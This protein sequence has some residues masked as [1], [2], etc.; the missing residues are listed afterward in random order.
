[1]IYIAYPSKTSEE[2]KQVFNELSETFKV[3]T[4]EDRHQF[5][6][7]EF[8]KKSEELLKDSIVFMAEFSEPSSGVEIETNW[9][10]ENKIPIIFFLREGSDYPDSL[11]DVYL[12]VIRYADAEEL[13]RKVNELLNE[14]YLEESKQEFFEYSDKKQY[15]AYKKGWKRKY[16]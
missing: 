6:R 7:Y 5:S 2:I 14:E 3:T 8:V 4:P 1:M 12:R 16:K 15:K 9:A 13:R 10:V 11:K